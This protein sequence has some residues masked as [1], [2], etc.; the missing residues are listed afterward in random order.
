MRFGLFFL[1]TILAT[2]GPAL[3]APS[4]AEPPAQDE[5]RARLFPRPAALEPQ[6]RFCRAV[7]AEYSSHQIV[8]H[9]AVY[10]DKI[11]KVLD[12]RP[13]RDDG[14]DLGELARLE[15][16]QT[17]LEMDRI[18]PTLLRLHALGPNPQGLTAEEQH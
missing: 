7:F 17:D 4:A 8:L 5:H 2:Q 9:D 12:F 15:R 6:F 1:A 3:A 18:R 10:L 16:I 11:Y 14:M 13:Q